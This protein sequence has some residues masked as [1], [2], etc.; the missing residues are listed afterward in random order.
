ML[1]KL[2][3][4]RV[5]SKLICHPAYFDIRLLCLRRKF[6]TNPTSFFIES[7]LFLLGDTF[8]WDTDWYCI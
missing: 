2:T 1:I 5:L 6:Q 8:Y 3:L 4:S 7:Q